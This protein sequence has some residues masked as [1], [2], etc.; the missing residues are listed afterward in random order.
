V[1]VDSLARQ[2]LLRW[3]WWQQKLQRSVLWRNLVLLLLWLGVFELGW[4]VEYTH[5]ASVWFPV[6]GLTFASL[7]LFGI[8]VVPA[9]L[10]GCVLISFYT[11]SHYGI[12]LSDVAIF[13]A[14]LLFGLAHILPYAAGAA[15][16]RY[17]S[18]R[19]RDLSHIIVVFLLIAALSSLLATWLVL[20]SLVI[21]GMMPLSDV[22]ATW[23]PFWIGDMAGVL[24][25][26][27]FFIGLFCFVEPSVLF[28]LTD[29]TALHTSS[30][31]SQIVLK[32]AVN[33]VF[34]TLCMLLAQATNSANSAFAIFFMVIP[35]MWLA[36]SESPMLNVSS[37]ALS[38]FLVA[39]WVN[40]LELK[41]FVMVY[42]F[43]ISVIA[44][45]TLFGLAIP[46]LLADNMQLRKVAF[47]D[48]L[49][50]VASRERL[51]QR[52]QL[53]MLRA[54]YDNSPFSLMV[55]DIDH[56]KSINDQ[57]GHHVGDQ[58]LQQMAR[59]VQAHLRPTDLLG[60]FGG[61][62]FVVLLPQTTLDG[63]AQIAQRIVEQIRQVTVAD[64]HAL[65][66]S[67]GVAQQSRAEEYAQLFRR[68][69]QALYDAKQAGRDCV[70][71]AD[72]NI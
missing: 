49:T 42:Q 62:E 68:A 47:T 63:A 70:R 48:S 59:L 26:A 20:P 15:L 2:S 33:V 50:Q 10:T 5:H 30:S 72:T 55:F 57:F 45:N 52:A 32:L 36:C 31:R 60:R 1:N 6:A 58:A 61:D 71:L 7:L 28:R 11:A 54:G 9:L 16:L 27:P 46:T 65:S 23:L 18:R 39:F 14:G 37:V 41:D 34:L 12:T 66:A 22:A 44:A 67:F 8:Q 13:E 64:V 24:V 25:L 38:S 56:F 69:D 17:V 19:N 4:L 35:H 51:E 43:A 29:L 21:S 53:D 40:V 3:P